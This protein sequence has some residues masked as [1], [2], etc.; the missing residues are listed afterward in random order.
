MGETDDFSM[1]VPQKDKQIEYDAG[2]SWSCASPRYLHLFHPGSF[3]EFEDM[4][5]L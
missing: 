1:L 2:L 4:S 5:T 3:F